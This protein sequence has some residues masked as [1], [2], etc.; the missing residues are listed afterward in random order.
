MR[1]SAKVRSLRLGFFSAVLLLLLVS[2]LTL[3]P[4][5]AAQDHLVSHQALQQQVQATSAKR[6]QNIADLSRFLST[7][8]AEHAMKEHHINP[9]EVQNAIPTLSS[10]E[11][12]SLAARANHAQQQF[13]AGF[14]SSGMLLVVI[15]AIVV[16][17][18]VIA[19]H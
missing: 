3:E 2:S 1:S 19:V 7:P 12:A 9:A 8:K 17:V 4:L 18:I 11:L 16:A 6:Q 5:A 15:I 13:A 10:H 14:L